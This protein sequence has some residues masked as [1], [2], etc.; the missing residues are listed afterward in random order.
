MD[1]AC[2]RRYPFVGCHKR[3]SINGTITKPLPAS[4]GFNQPFPLQLFAL[5]KLS[6]G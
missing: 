6:I 1:T 5:R 4:F 3:L 2:D